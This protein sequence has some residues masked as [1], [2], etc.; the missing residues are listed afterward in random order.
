M[1]IKGMCAFIKVG[2]QG[3]MPVI[4]RLHR[5]ETS[6][7]R[8]DFEQ[9][10]PGDKIEAKILRKTVENGRT[11]VELTK[12]REHMKAEGLDETL[13]KLLSFDTLQNGQQVEA[14][15]TDVVSNDIAT[16]VSCPVQVQVSPFIRSS[17]LF[18]EILD[19]KTILA[20]TLPSISSYVT[21]NFKIGQRILL[22]HTQGRFIHSQ[23]AKKESN[24]YEKGELVVVRFVKYLKGFGVTVQL[25]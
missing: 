16:Q 8:N 15:I 24:S 10:K 6:A 11:M 14:I 7:K 3:K 19:A 1:T 9:M 2:M 4:G 20:Q 21:S 5:I 25:D 13:V 18:S 22:T 17:L 12:R 23:S